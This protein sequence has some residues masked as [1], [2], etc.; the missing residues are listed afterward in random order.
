MTG[1]GRLVASFV[2][3]GADVLAP[4]RILQGNIGTFRVGEPGG[5]P[6]TTAGR[7]SWPRH[8]PTPQA[9]DNILGYLWAKEAYGAMMY[10]GAVTDL[11]IA[12]SLEDPRWRPLMLGVAREVLAQ[13]PVPP[14]ASTGSSPTTWRARWPA[15]RVQPGQRQIPLRDLSRP[16]GAPPPDRGRRHRANC[17]AR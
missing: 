17:P 13:A 14:E 16:D 9:T 5:G 2:N 10:A 4:G 3:F 8:C 7:A 11:S 6:V 15:G 12:D 1:P